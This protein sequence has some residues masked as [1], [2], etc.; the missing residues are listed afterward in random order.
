MGVQT[1]QQHP[2]FLQSR[3]VRSPFEGPPNTWLPA[4][5]PPPGSFFQTVQPPPALSRIQSPVR[6]ITSPAPPPLVSTASM[7]RPIVAGSSSLAYHQPMVVPPSQPLPPLPPHN[8]R[9]LTPELLH[10]LLDHLSQ[11]LGSPLAFNGAQT[12]LVVHGGAVMLL[13][14]TLNRLA[15]DLESAAEHYFDPSESRE[16]NLQ[17]LGLFQRRTSTRDVDYIARGF[18]LFWERRGIPDAVERLIR[19]VKETAYAFRQYGIGEDWVNSDADVSLPMATNPMTHDQYDPVAAAAL[20]L[21]N[22]EQYTVYESPNGL[23]RLVGVSPAWAVALKIVRYGPRDWADVSL[24]LRNG[25]YVN[26]TPE[27]VWTWLLTQCPDMIFDQ[28]DGRYQHELRTRIKHAVHMFHKS[29]SLARPSIPSMPP[30]T[31][32]PPTVGLQDHSGLV[33]FG[34][35]AFPSSGPIS[36][37]PSVPFIPPK[38][39]PYLNEDNSADS[40][41]ERL[42]RKSRHRSHRRRHRSPSIS[43]S[44]DRDYAEPPPTSHRATDQIPA[45]T[46]GRHRQKDAKRKEKRRDRERASERKSKTDAWVER[47]PLQETQPQMTNQPQ[48][49]SPT[50]WTVVEPPAPHPS[51]APSPHGPRASKSLRNQASIYDLSHI[52]SQVKAIQLQN[53]ASSQMLGPSAHPIEAQS[54]SLTPVQDIYGR[55]SDQDTHGLSSLRE[56]SGRRKHKR[57]KSKNMQSQSSSGVPTNSLGLFQ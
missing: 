21:N 38:E 43:S 30:L 44:E 45:D 9:D 8:T 15:K 55:Q 35:S 26:W 31:Q 29:S 52:Q 22:I 34:A 46:Y 10:R 32:A 23:L 3:D 39:E 5:S 48:W 19:C 40:E 24:I 41:D 20:Q 36:A 28:R 4:T 57:S 12:T 37:Q 25:G 50:P 17:K 16:K 33:S 54:Q 11:L 18:K 14:S 42:Y 56:S 49:A 6:P 7:G 27:M 51:L 47:S 13:H 1:L 2:Q 53:S